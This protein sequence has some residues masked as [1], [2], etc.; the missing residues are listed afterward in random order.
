MTG[1]A[2]IG[3]VVGTC[4]GFATNFHQDALY[5]RAARR[6]NG[7][8]VPEARLIYGCAGAIA[9]PIGMWIFS[10]TQFSSVHW[11]VSRACLD[12][13]GRLSDSRSSQVPILA[14]VPMVWGIYAIF[15][16]VQTYLAD[17]YGEYASSAIAAQGFMRNGRFLP[18]RS[19]Y[20]RR[21]ADAAAFVSPAFA[22]ANPLYANFVR[23]S[24]GEDRT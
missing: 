10:W 12:A 19:P 18:S 9:F 15:Q 8:P 20:A 1:L 22:A 5:A 11:I 4:L 3:L 17:A 21:L 14:L 23:P 16:A 24:L 13:L 6:N 2:Y 7:V